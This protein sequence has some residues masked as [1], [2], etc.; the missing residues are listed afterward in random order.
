MKSFPDVKLVYLLTVPAAGYVASGDVK[1]LYQFLLETS[2]LIMNE[3]PF[4]LV[5]ASLNSVSHEMLFV[6][7]EMT[8]LTQFRND[9]YRVRATILAQSAL[10]NVP[11]DPDDIPF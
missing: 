7:S 11:I 8:A 10:D 6:F 2:E 5:A 4:T 1:E 9:W 3:W